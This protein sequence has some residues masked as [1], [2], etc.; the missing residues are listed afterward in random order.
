MLVNAANQRSNFLVNVL[1][2]LVLTLGVVVIAVVYFYGESIAEK[3]TNLISDDL[4]TYDLLHKL[5]KG[6]I[7]QERYLYEFYINKRESDFS[8]GYTNS[9]QQG[10]DTLA[11]LQLRLGNV[12]PLQIIRE[13]LTSVSKVGNEFFLNIMEPDTDWDF[14]MEQLRLVSEIKRDTAHQIQFL[15]HQ[16]ERKVNVSEQKVLT[17]LE[18]VRFFVML[19][20]VITLLIAFV[21]T[22]A[23]RTYLVNSVSHQRLSLFPARNP[24]PIISLDHKS[25]VTYSNPATDS[26]LQRLNLP[27]GK[28]HLLLDKNIR[29][30]Q[31]KILSDT[32]IRSTVFEYEIDNL[33]FQC[34]LHWVEDQRQWDIHLTDVTERKRVQQELSYRA[35]HDQETGLKNRYE[36]E[37]SFTDLYAKTDAFVLGLIEIR[38]FNQLLTIRGLTVA[39]TVVKEV[40]LVIDEVVS[41]ANLTGFQV[42]HTGEKSFAITNTEGLSKKDIYSLVKQIEAKISSTIFHSQDQVRLDFGFAC[43]PEHGNDYTRLHKNALAALDKSASSEDK[44]HILF[45]V[46]LGTKLAYEQKLI[47]D[48]RVAI[49]EVEFELY[50]QPQLELQTGTIIGAEVLIRWQRDDEWVSPAEFIPLAEKAGLIDILGDWILHTSCQKARKLVDLGFYDLVV[51]VNISPLQFGRKDFLEK[52]KQALKDTQLSAKNLELEI[53]E[54]VIIYNEQETIATLE[55]LKSLG[56]QL[57]IDDFGTGYSSLNYLKKFNIDKLKIDQS[58][59]RNIQHESADQSIV[60]TIIELG[61]N[62]GLTLIAEGVEEQEQLNILKHMGCDEMQGYFFSRPLPEQEF[63]E[64]V[65]QQSGA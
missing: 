13:N 3:T 18:S 4:P 30:H 59:V 9:F 14:A 26:L 45:T 19:Y 64:F 2:S 21:V 6:L 32:S 12:Q 1:F 40:A 47:D 7:E 35:T 27:M 41:N 58:F 52:V 11:E 8:R 29:L 20:S 15:V 39:S 48:M 56:V 28:T 25:N 61:R 44:S 33:Y 38:S 51:A 42:Y 17:G 23:I 63:I 50:F 37:K 46:E 49:E 22:K 43:F 31:E 24:N 55:S 57:A 65:Q 53:T 16:T 60:R 34:D 10:L 5:E 36:L 54:G 62:L